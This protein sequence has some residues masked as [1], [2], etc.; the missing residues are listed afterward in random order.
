ME[1]SHLERTEEKTRKARSREK[2]SNVRYPKRLRKFLQAYF[3]KFMY[4]YNV[5]D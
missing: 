4:P 1:G 2:L 5:D 3:P